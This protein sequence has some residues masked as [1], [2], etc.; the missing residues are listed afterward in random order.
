MRNSSCVMIGASPS[1]GSSSST[2]FGSRHQRARDRE[3]LL[4]AAAHAPGELAA[5]ARRAA[6]TRVYQRSMS[7]ATSRSRRGVRAEPQVLVDGEVG[8]RAPALRNVR[9]A[10]RPR[11]APAASPTI[12]VAVERRSRPC[13]S[14]SPGERPQRRGLARAV[15][16]EDH[17]DLA[18]IDR[19]VD[20]VQHPHR[21]VAAG[22]LL[23]RR[24]GSRGR[25]SRGTPR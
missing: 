4:L 8:D 2:S 18:L 15:R 11:S 23:D 9:D 24:A 5:G 25:R 16:A 7:A 10:R 22:E 14:I 6:G 21:A 1:D 12:V 13:A 3:H 17:H 19:E 20:A